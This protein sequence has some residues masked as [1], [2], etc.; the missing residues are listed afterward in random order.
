MIDAPTA[1]AA[2]LVAE[3]VEDGETLARA[4]ALAGTIAAR[5]PLAVRLAKE[6]MLRSFETGLA[7]GLEFER[8]SFSLLAASEDR[9]EGIAAF[10]DKRQAS[11]EGR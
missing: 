10:L 3:V 2:G 6:S 9:K 4:F 1:L 5:S 11:F 7:A 8:K